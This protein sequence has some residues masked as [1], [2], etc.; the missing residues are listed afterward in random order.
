MGLYNSAK[1]INLSYPTLSYFVEWRP[2]LWTP[3]VKWLIG[4]PKRFIGKRVLDLG[5]RSGRMSCLFGLLGASVTGLEL[6]QVSLHE[7]WEEA[8]RWNLIGQVHFEH[9]DGNPSHIPG[10]NYDFIFTKSVLVVIDDLGTFLPGLALKLS[11][12][13]ELLAAENLTGGRFLKFVRRYFI[14]RRWRG[15]E[16]RFH[17]VDLK[18]LTI[19]NE[20][21]KIV[22]LKRYYGLVIAIRARKR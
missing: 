3:A 22:E 12:D 9:Y 17:G 1:D 6:N 2:L 15:F 16:S 14:H 20:V 7:A 4:D 11:R 18:F 5:C 8:K 10:D 21:F 13:G 19:L